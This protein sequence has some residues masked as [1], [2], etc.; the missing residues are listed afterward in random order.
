MF[1]YAV[2]VTFA[3]SAASALAAALKQLLGGKR[4]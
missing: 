1:R 4:R 2:I 3:A